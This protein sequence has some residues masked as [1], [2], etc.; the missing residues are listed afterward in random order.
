MDFFEAQDRARRRTN[1][2]VLLFGLAVAG[3][4]AA[5]YFSTLVIMHQAGGVEHRGRTYYYSAAHSGPIA[6]WNPRILLWAT[7]GTLGVVGLASLFKWS[8]MRDGGSAIAEMAGGRAVDLK[9]TDLRERKLLNVV[10][11]MAIASGIPTPAVYVL[12]DEPGINAFAAG[13]TTSDAAVA[14]SRGALDKLTR[15]E[16]QGV[17]GHEFSHILNGD[18]RL[19]V[20]ITAIVFGILVIGLLGQGVLRGLMYGRVRGGDKN[21]GGAVVLIGAIG[22]ALFLIGYVGYFFGRLIQAA[23]SR[24]REFL[25]DASAVQFTRNPAGLTGALK[26]IGG[27]TLGG[28][29]IGNN[30][31]EI[32]HFFFAQA[33]KS[34]FGGLWATHPPLDERIRA[35]EP[36]WDGKLF[37]PPEVV[38]IAHESSAIAGLG[39]N[40]RY[41]AEETRRREQEWQPAP[42]PLRSMVSTP[43]KPVEIVADIGALTDA[44]F[45]Q[46]RTLLDSIPPRLREAT[47]DPVSAQV[48]VYGI[49]LDGDRPMRDQQQALVEKHAGAA[50]AAALTALRPALSLL[51]PA[52]RLPLFQLTLPALRT[53]DSAG[54]DRF[55]TTLDEL[56]HADNRVTPFEYAL[57]KMLL[58]QL[59]LAQT[60]HRVIQYDSFEAV[61]PEISVVLS[62]LATL[63]AKDT[64]AAFAAGAA[65]LPLLAGRLTLLPPESCGLAQVDAALDKLAVSSLPIK[66]RLLVA[67]GH[68]IASDGTVT[69]SE[70]ELYRALAAT[71]DVPMPSLST[72]A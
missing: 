65:Q 18:M 44:H 66:K 63:S 28:T 12:E 58:S 42:P 20:R 15:D 14:I 30:T 9:T 38:D 31:A 23:V 10:E 71:L 49:L 43:F 8:Q 34:N 68:V 37:D 7:A 62:A 48:L 19:N 35:V 40:T 17:V 51:D 55:A 50:A 53:L 54:L 32:G 61:D 33:F 41:S 11:E 16:L 25:A 26:K 52:V 36:N 21:K 39:G 64:A 56:V 60:P 46:A 67:A 29:M 70:G 27:Y 69:A 57:Q 59:R 1:R 72:A 2:L 22:V 47:R 6:W 3:T 13:L 5:G 4:I 45:R 24:Q